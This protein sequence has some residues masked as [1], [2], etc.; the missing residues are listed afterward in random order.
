MFFYKIPSHIIRLHVNIYVFKRE[1]REDMKRRIQMLLAPIMLLVCLMVGSMFA[2]AETEGTVVDGSRLTHELQAEGIAYP[3]LRGTYFGN[4]GGNITVTGQRQVMVTGDTVARQNVDSVKVTI[5][6]QQL[7]GDN[8][9]TI[10][11]YGP[12]VKYNTYYVAVSKTYSVAGGYYYR[13]T[14]SHTVIEGDAFES[15]V[16][17]T[18]GVWVS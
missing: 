3:K 1:R 8:W 7:K 4:G 11:S 10:A 13:M 16:S 12:T 5:H 18:N 14:G 6:L 2:S 17:S 9:V 15:A